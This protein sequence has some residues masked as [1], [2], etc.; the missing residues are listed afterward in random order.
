[1]RA[2]ALALAASLLF[3][4]A[5]AGAENGLEMVVLEEAS[6]S[7]KTQKGDSVAVH[8]RGTL[9]AD[10]TQFDA[11]YDR[12]EPLTFVLGSGMVIQGWDQGLLDMCPGEERRLTIPPELAYGNRAVGPIKAGSTLGEYIVGVARGYNYL[13]RMQF[14]RRNS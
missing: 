2:A 5:L 4:A 9:K 14:S 10:N 7:R 11:S 8:Y 6:C 12:G 1:M 3:P 13:T